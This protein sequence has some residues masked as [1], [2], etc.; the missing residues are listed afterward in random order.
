VTT[1]ENTPP[2]PGESTTVGDTA[3]AE[4]SPGTGAATSGDQASGGDGD[5]VTAVGTT[6]SD[7]GLQ[8]DIVSAGGATEGNAP[9]PAEVAAA[10]PEPAPSTQ[11]SEAQQETDQSLGDAKSVSGDPEAQGRDPSQG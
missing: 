4:V 6:T 9:N 2:A 1:P 11:P 8:P 7:Q 10:S 5:P 3:D